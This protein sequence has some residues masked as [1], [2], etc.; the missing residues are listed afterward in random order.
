MQLSCPKNINAC[1]AHVTAL[2]YTLHKEMGNFKK[3]NNQ[4]NKKQKES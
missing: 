4:T 2:F 1:I 3:K